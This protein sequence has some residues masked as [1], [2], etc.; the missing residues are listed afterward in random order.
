MVCRPAW[1]WAGTGVALL[2]VPE[3][4][5]KVAKYPTLQEPIWCCS[6]SGSL[7]RAAVRGRQVEDLHSAPLQQISTLEGTGMDAW[8]AWLRALVAG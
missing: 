3:G 1:T 6:Q 7:V 4:D 2:S 5:D 8:L